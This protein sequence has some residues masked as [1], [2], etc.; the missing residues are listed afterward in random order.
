MATYFC[1]FNRKPIK[2]TPNLQFKDN[3]WRTSDYEDM[4]AA[5]RLMTL[6]IWLGGSLEK[7]FNNA[8]NAIKICCFSM[9]IPQI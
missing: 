1:E 3:C 7:G 8:E 9:R 5:G 2:S 6:I 4:V